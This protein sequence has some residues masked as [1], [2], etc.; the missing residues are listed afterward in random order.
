VTIQEAAKALRKRTISSVELTRDSLRRIAKLEPTLRTFIT[1]TEEAAEARAIQAD[2]EL[3]AGADRGP[4]HGIPVAVKDVF[5]TRGIRTTC[6][7]KLF[8]D[9]VPERDAAVVERSLPQI[10]TSGRCVIPGTWSGF[11]A[12]PAVAQEALWQPVWFSWRWG[13]TREDRF[14]FQPPSVA[15]WA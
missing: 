4:L 12:V 6:G 9:L 15:L 10:L 11:R 5:S 2:E 3:A 13:A 7:S 8:A 1:I 14:A